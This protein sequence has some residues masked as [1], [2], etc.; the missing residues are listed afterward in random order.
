[1]DID[2]GDGGAGGSGG[3]GGSGQSSQPSGNDP[4]DELSSDL[5]K[6]FSCMNTDDHDTLIEQFKVL[7]GEKCNQTNAE[8]WLDMN[9]W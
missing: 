6:K 7:L 9:N 5:L 4:M 3:G 2:F 1:M 8:F